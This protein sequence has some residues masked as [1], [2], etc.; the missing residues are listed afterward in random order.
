MSIDKCHII[1]FPK[2]SDQRG[3]LSFVEGKKHIPFDIARIYYLYDVPGGEARGAHAHRDLEQVIVPISGSFD[4]ELD[5][6]IQKKTFHLRKA[7]EGLYLSRMVWRNLTNFASGSVC[8]VMASAPFA[9][10]DYHRD[11]AKFL[12][13][14]RAGHGG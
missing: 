1:T 9:E 13:A 5:D 12:A 10:S 4:L 6:G 8:L 3:N 14:V 11:Y 7:N 2:I